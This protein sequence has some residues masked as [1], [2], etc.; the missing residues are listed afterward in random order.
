M[1]DF[2]QKFKSETKT[3]DVGDEYDPEYISKFNLIIPW[4]LCFAGGML[5]IILI[6]IY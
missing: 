1:S 5:Y 4:R 6:L 2:V 3:Y